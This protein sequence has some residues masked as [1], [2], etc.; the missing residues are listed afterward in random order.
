MF[1]GTTYWGVIMVRRSHGTGFDPTEETSQTAREVASF[2][3]ATILTGIVSLIALAFSGLS[4]YETV[5]KQ[6]NLH[7]YVPDTIAYTRD[8]NGS[9]E[10]IVLP[11]TVANS[12]ARDGV[13]SALKLQVKNEATGRTREFSA[14]F[15]AAPGYFSTKEDYTKGQSRPKSAFAPLSIPGRSA[16]TGTLLFYPKD[17]SKERV[18]P[19]AGKFSMTLAATMDAV[20]DLGTIDRFWST[21]I[22]PVDFIANLPTVSRYF[23][24]QAMTGR[25]VRLFIENANAN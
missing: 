25:S 1:A 21:D 15:I 17:F 18:I 7:L 6:A 24:A 8:P 16:F 20:Q 23:D 19:G 10:V 13:V 9:F 22:D 5:L 11:V 12:G 3:T 4:L 14:S 2:G